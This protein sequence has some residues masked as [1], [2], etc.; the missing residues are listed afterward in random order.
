MIS[1][2]KFAPLARE[3]HRLGSWTLGSLKLDD[4]LD[5]EGRRIQE[6][7]SNCEKLFLG[8][9]AKLRKTTITF[10]PVCLSVRPHD[11]SQLSLDGFS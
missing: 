11:T 10:M 3:K 5:R 1:A 9:F 4:D 2:G 8:P 7:G 6:D